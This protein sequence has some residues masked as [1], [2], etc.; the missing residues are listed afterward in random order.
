MIFLGAIILLKHRILYS[1]SLFQF[2]TLKEFSEDMEHSIIETRSNHIQHLNELAKQYEEHEL[3][4]FWEYNYDRVQELSNDYPNLLRSSLLISCITNLEKTFTDIHND[5]RVETNLHPVSLSNKRLEGSTI[6]KVLQSIHEVL[7]M[8]IIY[9][10]DSWK[11]VVLYI[12][13]RN[14]VIHS[15]GKIHPVEHEGLFNTVKDL[16]NKG[17]K[18][19]ALNEYHELIFL[20]HFSKNVIENSQ[21]LLK[22]FIK[23]I[24]D[25]IKSQKD[26]AS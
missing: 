18:F 21:I 9:D 26:S 10:N 6:E 14:R 17:G 1:L 5:L 2:E 25:Y 15:A 23:Q 20:D 11:N 12:K 8:D 3:D 19:I 4:T 13:I 24:D 22:L 7:P 16:Q